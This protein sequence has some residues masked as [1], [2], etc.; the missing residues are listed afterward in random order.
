MTLAP[1]EEIQI[2]RSTDLMMK[3]VVVEDAGIASI[4][5][6]AQGNDNQGQNPDAVAAKKK[7]DV[8]LQADAS[9]KIKAD[10]VSAKVKTDALA[11]IETD[12]AAKIT[13]DAAAKA[14]NEDDDDKSKKI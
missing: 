4:S 10:A 6:E 13:A 11:K 1:V 7:A 14:K 3:K 8:K 9:A 2:S 5:L 12:A